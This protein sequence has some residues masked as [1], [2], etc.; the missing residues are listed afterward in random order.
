MT[1]HGV[2]AEGQWQP[3]PV[4][5][6]YCFIFPAR[7]KSIQR[8]SCL[9]LVHTMQLRGWNNRTCWWCCWDGS[10]AERAGPRCDRCSCL[11]SAGPGSPSH[12]GGGRAAGR[13]AGVNGALRPA[14]A[15]HRPWRSGSTLWTCTSSSCEPWGPGCLAGPARWRPGRG[16]RSCCCWTLSGSW[17]GSPTWGGSAGCSWGS[18]VRLRRSREGSADGSGP[19][20]PVRCDLYLSGARGSTREMRVSS[21]QEQWTGRPPRGFP[22]SSRLDQ[23]PWRCSWWSGWCWRSCCPLPGCSLLGWC[24][25]CRAESNACDGRRS[26]R[27]LQKRFWRQSACRAGKGILA[28]ETARRDDSCWGCWPRW[29]CLGRRVCRPWTELRGC[30]NCRQHRGAGTRGYPEVKPGDWPR[31][32]LWTAWPMGRCEEIEMVKKTRHDRR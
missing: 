2:V 24:W 3:N 28:W 21:C 18:C 13:D 26:L 5:A 23:P 19:P 32:R 25:R 6:H 11:W 15:P 27:G 8:L 22:S 14:T 1:E 9:V 10:P 12:W 31:T 30:A 7:D 4:L 17:A 20:L 16:W 29:T